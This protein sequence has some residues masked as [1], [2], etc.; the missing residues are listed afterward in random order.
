M[1]NILLLFITLLTASCLT[2]QPQSFKYQAVARNSNGIIISNANIGLKIE[3][4]KGSINSNAVYT[5]TFATT[6]NSIGIIN[7]NIGEGAPV[8]ATF[9]DI[10]WGNDNYFLHIAIDVNGGTSYQ[11]MGTTQLLSVPYSLYTGSIFVKYSND[12]LYIGD[13]YVII[14]GDTPPPGGTVTDFDGN[15]YE[16]VTIGS[17]TWMKENLRSLHYADGTPINGVWVYD[18]NE[19]NAAIWGRLY[20]WDAAMNNMSAANVNRANV[21]GAC[22]DGWHMPSKD[23]FNELVSFLGS[24]AGWKLKETGTQYWNAPNSNTNES[25]FSA[26]GAGDKES[27]SGVYEN[28]K[29]ITEFWTSTENSNTRAYNLILYQN[30]GGAP[31]HNND[32]ENGFSI[33]CVKN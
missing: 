2:A 24:G 21:Q 28:M 5:E 14:G 7:V 33:R 20:N 6:S 8:T 17:Q 4:R 30:Q 32:K 13:Q 29:E 12:T 3:I 15:I 31:M 1:K 9:P 26:I 19:S 27:V 22:P 11:D 16:T 23:E 25:E 10:N 18:D